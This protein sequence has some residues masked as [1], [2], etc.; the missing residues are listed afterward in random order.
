MTEIN[1]NICRL[2]TDD[3]SPRISRVSRLFLA[4]RGLRNALF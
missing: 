2:S 3:E 4:D 1:I